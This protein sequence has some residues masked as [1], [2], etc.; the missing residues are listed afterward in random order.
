MINTV[1]FVA[2]CTAPEQKQNIPE[3]TLKKE[4]K[5]QEQKK[6][7]LEEV[8]FEICPYSALLR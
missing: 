1:I 4:V 8:I 2:R 3:G 5:S 7:E 6:K